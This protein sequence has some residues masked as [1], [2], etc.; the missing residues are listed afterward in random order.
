VQRGVVAAFALPADRRRD[1]EIRRSSTIFYREF[2]LLFHE[3]AAASG[4][5]LVSRDE[6]V[7]R[8]GY[9]SR[10][11]PTRCCEFADATTV[12]APYPRR[13]PERPT[14]RLSTPAQN[15]TVPPIENLTDRRGDEPQFVWPPGETGGAG[16]RARDP[17][18]HAVSATVRCAAACGN[19]CRESS[20]GDSDG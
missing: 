1:R 5:G 2:V 15:L 17:T 14:Q 13:V 12:R 7:D 8:P 16:P 20:R 3:L 4:S 10:V 6:P 19:C 9:S 11:D 18:A